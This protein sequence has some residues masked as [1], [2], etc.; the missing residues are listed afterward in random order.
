MQPDQ[1]TQFGNSTVQ[2]G[3]LNGRAYLMRL[4][5]EDCPRIVSRLERLA[6][7][8]GYTKIFAKVPAGAAED[9]AE[10]GYRT[11]A[12]VPGFFNG[13]ESGLFMGR[14][15]ADWR[16]IPANAAE[17]RDVLRTARAKARPCAGDGLS[18]PKCG[19]PEGY[20]LRKLGPE[21]AEDM[22]ALYAE[23]FESYPFPIHDPDYLRGT[24][25]DD[26]HYFAAYRGDAPAALCSAEVDRD[27]GA[28]EMTDFATLPAHRGRGLACHLLARAEREMA[29]QGLATL[30]TI[31]R[32]ASF[33]MNIT[34]ARAGYGFAG[35][36]PNNTN[37]AGGLESMNVWHKSLG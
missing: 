21:H 1:V 15:F 36:L 14:Y 20:R 35:T 32:A 18:H 17:L 22:A 12:V 11:E 37:I 33:G 3:P 23:V 2:H 13:E 34:F 25:N 4:D 16:R 24:M 6:E 8:N 26:V 31:A 29:A 9:F 30:Y 27:G 19:L 5:P 7:D 10:A 28:A